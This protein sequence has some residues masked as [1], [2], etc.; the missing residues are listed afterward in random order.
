M[1]R[2]AGEEEKLGKGDGKQ[3]SRGSGAEEKV[4]KGD[5]KEGSRGRGA[6][7][8]VGQREEGLVGKGRVG[9]GKGAPG[10]TRPTETPGLGRRPHTHT[11]RKDGGAMLFLAGIAASPFLVGLGK[12][13]H[14]GHTRES[15]KEG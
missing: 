7:E 12:P 8:G 1:G 10:N 5:R 11:R 14:F 9:K 15:A 13:G 4:G 2:R 3:G 6:E